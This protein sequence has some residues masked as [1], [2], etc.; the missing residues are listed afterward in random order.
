MGHPI[1]LLWIIVSPKV[2]GFTDAI[3]IRAGNPLCCDY[4]SVGSSLMAAHL[5]KIHKIGE[6]KK[7]EC[8]VC[9]K[10][11]ASE[12]YVRLHIQVGSLTRFYS[13]LFPPFLSLDGISSFETT[14]FIFFWNSSRIR[15]SQGIFEHS[16]RSFFLFDHKHSAVFLW[17]RRSEIVTPNIC[18]ISRTRTWA[19]ATT[20]ARFRVAPSPVSRLPLSGD[21]R[22]STVLA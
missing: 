6:E 9:G 8:E 3:C 22:S 18:Q 5:Q 7:V 19:C 13:S 17:R 20:S 14:E 2:D 10:H 11:Y 1:V 21:T 15:Q 4:R 16:Q 12:H